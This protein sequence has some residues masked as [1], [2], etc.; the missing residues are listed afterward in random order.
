LLWELFHNALEMR[1]E[2]W[3]VTK[4]FRESIAFELSVRQNVNRLLDGLSDGAWLLFIE[5]RN[6][7]KE[8]F[9]LNPVC[10]R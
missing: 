3:R 4:G 6:D 10:F 8:V 9:D 1:K 5:V 7:F 2:D